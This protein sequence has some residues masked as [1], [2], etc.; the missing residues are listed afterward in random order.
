MRTGFE[1]SVEGE[2]KLDDELVPIVDAPSEAH[3]ETVTDI[4][5]SF[6]SFG[7]FTSSEDT[8]QPSLSRNKVVGMGVKVRE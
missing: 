6:F 1:L 3:S 7:W 8:K 2:A 5:A 4:V